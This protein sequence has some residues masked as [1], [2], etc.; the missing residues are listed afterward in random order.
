M[1]FLEDAIKETPQ[2]KILDLPGK[3]KTQAKEVK[4]K[5]R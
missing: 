4:E 1:R 5:I 3:D 2:I